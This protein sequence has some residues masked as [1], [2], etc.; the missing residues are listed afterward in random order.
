MSTLIEYLRGLNNVQSSA[1]KIQPYYILPSVLVLPS[2]NQHQNINIQESSGQEVYQENGKTIQIKGFAKLISNE[3][4][5]EIEET[6]KANINFFNK[7]EKNESKLNEA[8]SMTVYNLDDY[9]SDKQTTVVLN[10]A[11]SKTTAQV[12][13]PYLP[14]H[15]NNESINNVELQNAGSVNKN[16]TFRGEQNESWVVKNYSNN[17]YNKELYSA[18][19][20]TDNKTTVE[21]K[22]PLNTTIHNSTLSLN[23]ELPLVQDNRWRKF[24][25]TIT[26]YPFTVNGFQPLAGLYYDG[27]LHRPLITKKGFKPI[28]EVVL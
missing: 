25:T 5:I 3:S 2:V 13:G 7:P 21:A 8:S 16:N 27:F 14:A 23:Y 26:Y 24:L 28:K 4:S 12:N 11:P 18:L 22:A 1:Q 9:D 6:K 17:L 20:V 19:D 10:N 15:N